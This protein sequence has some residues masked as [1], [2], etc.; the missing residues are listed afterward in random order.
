MSLLCCTGAFTGLTS[1]WPVSI[2]SP[3]RG[4]TSLHLLLCT[5]TLLYSHRVELWVL[6]PIQAVVSVTLGYAEPVASL[7][8]LF[9]A[10]GRMW[11]VDR[12]QTGLKNMPTVDRETWIGITHATFLLFGSSVSAFYLFWL[13]IFPPACRIN[14]TS[15]GHTFV[16][17]INLLKV[18]VE[19][20]DGETPARCC[21][22]GIMRCSLTEECFRVRWDPKKMGGGERWRLGKYSSDKAIKHT[23]GLMD[24]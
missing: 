15:K 14:L 11:D 19:T 10:S 20:L 23:S 12:H 18:S 6:E 8:Q 9:L 13:P 17:S 21:Q 2:T 4:L 16:F 3:A 5:I 7:S 24:F 22:C 1:M